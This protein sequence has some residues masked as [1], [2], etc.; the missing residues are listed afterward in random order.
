VNVKENY[1]NISVKEIRAKLGGFV[2][3]DV[4]SEKQMK[5]LQ[6]EKRPMTVLQNG[7]HYTGEWII[8]TDV[9]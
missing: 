8:G 6:R 4:E 2:Y 7:A 5:N 3:N 9:R 1:D